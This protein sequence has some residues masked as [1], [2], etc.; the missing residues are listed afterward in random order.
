MWIIGWVYVMY[1]CTNNHTAHHIT[2]FTHRCWLI[3][4]QRCVCSCSNAKT[5]KYVIETTLIKFVSKMLLIPSFWEI[6]NI[7]LPSPAHYNHYTVITGWIYGAA[8]P[9]SPCLAGPLLEMGGRHRECKWGG[10][11]GNERKLMRVR[12][13]CLYIWSQFYNH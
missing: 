5:A 3:S 12:L 8:R 9:H 10:G 2:A 11:R 7:F 13:R 6:V 4:V 1:K